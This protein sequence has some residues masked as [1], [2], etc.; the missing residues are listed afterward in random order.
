MLDDRFRKILRGYVVVTNVA[1]PIVLL[2]IL[3]YIIDVLL[4]LTPLFLIVG[5]IAGLVI[6]VTVM[7]FDMR[8]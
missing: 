4:V 7:Y 6:S 2:G 8:K 3:G 5:L 1:V